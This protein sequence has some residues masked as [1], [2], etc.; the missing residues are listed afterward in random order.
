MY[1]IGDHVMFGKKEVIICEVEKGT[2]RQPAVYHL[3]D[4]RKKLIGSVFAEQISH[5]NAKHT[6]PYIKNVSRVHF[7]SPTTQTHKRTRMSSPQRGGNRATRR[8]KLR[9]KRRKT[10]RRKSNRRR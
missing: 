2:P 9:K 3:C 10:N 5:I 1:T 4:E 6:T 8:N 7:D